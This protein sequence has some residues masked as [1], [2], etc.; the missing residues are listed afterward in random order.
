MSAPSVQPIEVR[1]SDP[2]G[3]DSLK[4]WHTSCGEIMV[5]MYDETP[6]GFD[7][8]NARALVNGINFILA[9]VGE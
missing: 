8:D 6:V 9:G 7:Y 5:Q 4:I 3:E 2:D 1:F